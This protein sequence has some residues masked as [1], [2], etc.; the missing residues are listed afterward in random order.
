[1]EFTIKISRDKVARAAKSAVYTLINPSF[2]KLFGSSGTS[3]TNLID[4]F[5]TI[6][7]LFIITNFLA[8]RVAKVPV[9]V[10]KRTGA[11]APNS[12]LW[13]L[14]DKPNYYQSWQEFVKTDYAFYNIL[15][16]SF[17]YGMPSVGFEGM[18]KS[19]YNLPPSNIK[20]KI[21]NRNLPV[22]LNEIIGYEFDIGGTKYNLSIDEV[23]H[24]RF[25]NLRHDSGAWAYGISK[26]IPG[27]KI[28]TELKAIY[29]AKTS[30]IANRGA[31]GILSNESEIPDKEATEQ[32]QELFAE[33]YGLGIDQKKII[34]TTQRLSWQQIALNIQELQIIENAK[35]SFEKL[36]QLSE[37]DP[38]IFSADG[39][40]FANKEAAIKD[41]YKNVI[42][43]DVDEFYNNLNLFI[44]EGYNGDKIVPD[45]DQ[46]QE[47]ED[48]KKVYTDMITAQIKSALITPK[49]GQEILYGDR[50]KE[51][52]APDEYYK[53]GIQPVE[54]EPELEPAPKP[55]NQTTEEEEPEEETD[56]EKA[57]KILKQPTNGSSKAKILD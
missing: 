54:P 23:L 32:V 10:V 15:G 57:L 38:V 22:Y 21:R 56:L 36:C 3:N 50:F 49:A 53:A 27:D 5:E 28:N 8:K 4:N 17:T 45:W 9:K 19:L 42:K 7:D 52:P 31:L 18:I 33:S 20:V 40:T 2:H 35:Y 34:A 41:L 13:K 11:N 46:V 6:P 29:D 39:S 14:I 37:I 12:E 1:M 47:L 55:V 25:F 30:I 16:N 48:D 44:S 26:Y 24:N 51:N 43:G